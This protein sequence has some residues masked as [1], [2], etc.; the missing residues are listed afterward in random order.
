MCV[1]VFFSLFHPQMCWLPLGIRTPLQTQLMVKLP[2]FS[3]CLLGRLKLV[4]LNNWNVPFQKC[5]DI[6]A[7]RYLFNAFIAYTTHYTNAYKLRIQT[8]WSTTIDDLFKVW[9]KWKV[10]FLGKMSLL[11]SL[12]WTSRSAV[13]WPRWRRWLNPSHGCHP[14]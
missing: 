11:W 5:P 12:V 8:L 6:K 1:C 3:S 4:N 2:S 14:P 7:K 10:C 9:N 13:L